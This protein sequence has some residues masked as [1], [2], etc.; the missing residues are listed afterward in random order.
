MLLDR[1]VKN[2]D[3]LDCVTISAMRSTVELSGVKYRLTVSKWYLEM[4]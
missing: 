2:L 3:M 1:T 4:F